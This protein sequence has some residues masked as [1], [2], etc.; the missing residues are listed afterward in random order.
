[1]WKCKLMYQQL[2]GITVQINFDPK[3]I[4]AQILGISVNTIWLLILK[5]SMLQNG[6]SLGK[7]IETPVMNIIK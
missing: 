1:M 3:F 7:N 6:V 4:F 5:V 2:N